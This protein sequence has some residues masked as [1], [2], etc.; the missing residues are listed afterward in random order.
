MERNFDKFLS[1]WNKKKDRNNKNAK[2][3]SSLSLKNFIFLANFL[4]IKIHF[5]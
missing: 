1:I 4:N 2:S 5:I 3:V